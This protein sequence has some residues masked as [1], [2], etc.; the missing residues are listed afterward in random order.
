MAASSAVAA[1]GGGAI[2]LVSVWTATEVAANSVAAAGE[3]MDCLTLAA[4]SKPNGFLVLL[5]GHTY[6]NNGR[7]LRDHPHAQIDPHPSPTPALHPQWHPTRWPFP[8]DVD[9]L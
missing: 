3:C 6:L 9:A 1:L 8:L 2:D 4:Q 7:S 5:R